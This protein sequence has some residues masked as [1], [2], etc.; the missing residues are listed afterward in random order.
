MIIKTLNEILET[1]AKLNIHIALRFG[2]DKQ[3]EAPI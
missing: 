3:F 2:L 1:E